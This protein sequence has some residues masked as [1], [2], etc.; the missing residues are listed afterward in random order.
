MTKRLERLGGA[1]GQIEMRKRLVHLRQ[2]L[3]PI[4]MKALFDF[5]CIGEATRGDRH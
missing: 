3:E 2:A 4:H 5:R 1:A